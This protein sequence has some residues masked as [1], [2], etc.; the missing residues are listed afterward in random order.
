MCVC[1]RACAC[2]CAYACARAHARARVHG[3]QIMWVC[4]CERVCARA[5][6]YV[7]GCVHGCMRVSVWGCV[8]AC[9]CVRACVCVSYLHSLLT[10]IRKP[11]QHRLSGSVL[12]FTPIVNKNIAS[13][14]FF[15]CLY[16]SL[17]YRSMIPSI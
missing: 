15:L 4:V 17:E 3:C 5:Y 11:T 14:C 12:H 10:L 6:V 16:Y 1:V 7:G 8:R 9:M 2:A 13:R